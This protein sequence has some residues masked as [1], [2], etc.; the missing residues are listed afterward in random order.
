LKF[1]FPNLQTAGHEIGSVGTFFASDAG[2]SCF[3]I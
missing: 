2:K 1:R 3:V